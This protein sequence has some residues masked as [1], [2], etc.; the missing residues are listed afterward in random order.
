MYNIDKLKLIKNT[1]EKCWEL[2]EILDNSEEDGTTANILARFYDSHM[3]KKTPLGNLLL[4]L[5]REI[6]KNSGDK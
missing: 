6:K 4:R 2:A 5:L 3:G 1:E